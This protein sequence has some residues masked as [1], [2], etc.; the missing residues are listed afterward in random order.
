MVEKPTKSVLS[1]CRR[2]CSISAP[3]SDFSSATTCVS[4]LS[5]RAR[6]DS[7]RAPGFR[8]RISYRRVRTT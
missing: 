6:G 1:A 7:A 8:L 3:L 2:G 4:V 5:P